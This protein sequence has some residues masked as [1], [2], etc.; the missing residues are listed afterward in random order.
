[1]RVPAVA[2]LVHFSI[3]FA[4]QRTG[5]A[6][7][8]FS[9]AGM[10][11]DRNI[12]AVGFEKPLV[13]EPVIAVVVRVDDRD[14][15]GL[16]HGAQLPDRHFGDLHRRAGIDDDD[17][18]PADDEDDV[19]HHPLVF[20]RRKSVGRLDHEDVRADPLQRLVLDR[21]SLA[22]CAGRG[23]GDRIEHPGIGERERAR[24]LRARR[25]VSSPLHWPSLAR[26]FI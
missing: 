5:I 1:M 24:F 11:V 4:P 20:G 21:R 6:F 13:P 17:P 19:R 10:R 18:V 3:E 14:D 25:V 23:I 22:V 26:G 2:S 15:R 8:R 9:R 12:L 16:G 7:D